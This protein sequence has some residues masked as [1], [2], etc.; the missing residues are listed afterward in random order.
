MAVSRIR[1]SRPIVVAE[2]PFI[3]APAEPRTRDVLG[4]CAHDFLGRREAI[5]GIRFL[6]ESRWNWPPSL[7]EAFSPAPVLGERSA[8][9]RRMPYL[10]LCDLLISGPQSVFLRYHRQVLRGMEVAYTLTAWASRNLGWWVG[11]A[12]FVFRFDGSIHSSQ[13]QHRFEFKSFV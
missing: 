4:R 8:V 11:S 10:N 13:I 9:L 7:G 6:A 2:K 1:V 5:F 12:L 3:V